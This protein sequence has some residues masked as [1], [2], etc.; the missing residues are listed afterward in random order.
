M[1]NTNNTNQQAQVKVVEKPVSPSKWTPGTITI[2]LIF[3][4][5]AFAATPY[6]VSKTR[7]IAGS[8]SDNWPKMNAGE[9]ILSSFLGAAIVFSAIP[10]STLLF[11][12]LLKQIEDKE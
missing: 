7:E 10:Y 12:G 5:I 1:A 3:A 6:F 11:F 8:V 4:G 2:G 9:K